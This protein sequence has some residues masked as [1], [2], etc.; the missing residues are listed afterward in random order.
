MGGDRVTEG[1]EVA[2]EDVQ[3]SFTAAASDDPAPVSA[4]D[5]AS[6]AAVD[7]SAAPVALAASDKLEAPAAAPGVLCVKGAARP[8]A[9]PPTESATKTWAAWLSGREAGRPHSDGL[10]ASGV[11]VV[12]V[13]VGKGDVSS[14]LLSTPPEA[15][16]ACVPVLSKSCA[17]G[18]TP[19][20]P[21]VGSAKGLGVKGVGVAD[22][23][24]QGE[25]VFVGSGV[26][27]SEAI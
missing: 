23:E 5:R 13:V 1:D 15:L 22:S 17:A 19:G 10:A 25:C 27:L 20:A 9:L 21:A 8:A 16:G 2:A 26:P 18:C 6:S 24:A 11:V 14:A 7:D 3:S 4:A 12:V